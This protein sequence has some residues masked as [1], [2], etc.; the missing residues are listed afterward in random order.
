M[1]G[2]DRQRLGLTLGKAV[3]VGTHEVRRRR[4]D[5]DHLLDEQRIPLGP[6]HALERGVVQAG[7][8]EVRNQVAALGW[9]QRLQQDGCGVDLS[10]TPSGALLEKVGPGHAEEQ[11]RGLARP[12]G[13]VFDQIEHGALRPVDVLEDEDQRCLLRQGV[14]EAGGPRG[15]LPR[16]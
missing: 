8:A 12:V 1:L 2:R 9:G 13:N 4:H 3:A 7:S 5:R 16:A 15:M 14:P 6:D 11:D 10:P